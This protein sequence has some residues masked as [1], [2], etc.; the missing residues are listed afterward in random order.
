MTMTTTH[1]A[2]RT[3]RYPLLLP[4]YGSTAATQV[5]V[6]LPPPPPPIPAVPSALSRQCVPHSRLEAYQSR[7]AN[8]HVNHDECRGTSRPPVPCCPTKGT[9]NIIMFGRYNSSSVCRQWLLAMKKGVVV[10]RRD[11]S[12]WQRGPLDKRARHDTVS[13][14]ESSH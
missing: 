10:W 2:I 8:C 3:S 14:N 11:F 1:F 7:D 4:Y 6:P 13:K 5:P 9:T 12:S